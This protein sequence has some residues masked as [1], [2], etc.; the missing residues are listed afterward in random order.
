MYSKYAP[1][2][3]RLRDIARI[4]DDK[5]PVN[6]HLGFLNLESC[7]ITSADPENSTIGSNIMSLCCIQPELR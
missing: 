2:Y 7:T 5:M 3:Y 1:L 4:V 6:R